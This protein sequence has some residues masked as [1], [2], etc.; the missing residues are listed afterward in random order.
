MVKE[1]YEKFYRAAGDNYAALSGDGFKQAKALTAWKESIAREFQN[2]KVERI[3][4]D[5][6]KIYKIKDNIEIE[7]E[8]SL[9]NLE[10][11]DVGVDVY[12]GNLAPSGDRL[13][14][15]FVRHLDGVTS[16]GPG[17][18]VFSGLLECLSTGNFGFKI[19]ITPSHPLIIDPYEMNL[20]KWE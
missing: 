11:G 20:V 8:V 10:P 14:H 2:I 19:R 13:D 12:Y 17:R 18:Y 15:S 16:A 1:Y 3:G 5:E 9:G 4:F 6:T 7:V